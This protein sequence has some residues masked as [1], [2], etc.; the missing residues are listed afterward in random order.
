[1]NR[2]SEKVKDIVEVCPFTHLE[3]LSADAGLTLA[4]YHF[5]D[6]T[7]ELMAKW[8][9]RI[10]AVGPGRG[11]ALALAGFRGVGKSHFLAVL[12]G[13]MSAPELRSKI[14]DEHVAACAERLS[15]KHGV[16]ARV[17]RGSG[18]T[19]IE[20]L[21]RA[22][23]EALD[24]NPNTL[25]DSLNDLLLKGSEKANDLPLVVLIDTALGR[26][27]RVA[28][29]DGPF[30]SEIAEAAKTLG[31]F[32]GVALD[33][34]IAGADGA[35]SSI[36]AS[37]TIDY[38]D[39]EHLYKI[40]DTHIFAKQSQK[41][42]VLKQLYEDY[43]KQLPAFRWSEQR[44]TS[45]YPLHPAILEIAPLI[46]LYVQD[47]ALLGF[48]SEAGVKILG[49]PAN[50]LIGVDEVFDSVEHKLRSVGE[51]AD[52]FT[53]Y[54]KL[55][56]EVIAKAAVHSRLQAKLI[57][58]GL[59][60]LSLDSRGATADEIAAAM[61]LSS[62]D[63]AEPL[64]SSFHSAQP[65]AVQKQEGDGGKARYCF[66]LG[67]ADE[68]EAVLTAA[69]GTVTDEAVW[70][71][72]MR[73]TAEKFSEVADVGD[74][75][76]PFSIEW[77][78][79]IHRGS[80]DWHRS[81][82]E[83]S[84]EIRLVVEESIS[85]VG[86]KTVPERAL[87]W[88]LPG[89]TGEEANSLK[90]FHLLQYDAEVRAAY[91]DGIATATHI[92]SIAAEKIWQRV[93]L[94]DSVLVDGEA[95]YK[96]DE[97]NA[98]ASHSLAQLFS[99]SLSPVL[100]ARSPFHP[101][102]S[103]TLSAK[104][105]G[106][107]IA[108]FFGGADRD[109]TE[110]QKL[111]E[112]FALP[113]GLAVERDGG[114]VP[115][116]SDAMLHLGLSQLILADVDTDKVI[117]LA[118]IADRLLASP[119]GLTQEAQHL[120]LGALVGQKQFEFVTSSGNRIN[121]RSLDLQIIWD[122][123][124]GIAK[125]L[126]EE[127]SPARLVAWAKLITGNDSIT[128]MERSEDRLLIIDSLCTWLTGWRENFTL[129]KFDELSDANLNATIWKAAAGVRRS[130]EAMADAVEALVQNG[131]SLEECLHA[132]AELFTD[133]EED[134]ARKN[135]DLRAIRNWTAAAT[136]R[137]V[138]ANYLSHCA[139]TDNAEIERARQLVLEHLDS[140]DADFVKSWQAFKSLYAAFY[141]ERH[142]AASGVNAGFAEAL[143]SDSWIAFE[144]L[145][146]LPQ[147]DPSYM[148]QANELIRLARKP[149]CKGD[150]AAE[151][152]ERPYCSCGFDAKGGAIY[153]ADRLSRVTDKCLKEFAEKLTTDGQILSA[154]IDELAGDDDVELRSNVKQVLE[155]LAATGFVPFMSA[156]EIRLIKL[157]ATRLAQFRTADP[158]FSET[159]LDQPSD[160][161]APAL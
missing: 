156:A 158:S 18:S 124:V 40:V 1:M 126:H 15:R 93:F 37:Y 29:D 134:Y 73:Q 25:S 105:T 143:Q 67:A 89:L 122:D 12:A 133:S 119:F 36:S 42:S 155:D 38:L 19:L 27:T 11:A 132:I 13:V 138:I 147:I 152:V 151:L 57:L 21:R 55:E 9:D 142:D 14:Q 70:A 103:R 47:F 87:I 127:Y 56:A 99:S 34:D 90:R 45:L 48:A 141:V 153:F 10:A 79:A 22:I 75:A 161:L 69:L 76:T 50:S 135:S 62:G 3:D 28:R 77:R 98:R 30:L 78:G 137:N 130:F 81:V 101:E 60:I 6:I 96:F 33:D 157:A 58:K 88:R 149:A 59:F 116:A 86:A 5:T 65:D 104:Q 82:E 2:I 43:R 160:V 148:S 52:A 145:S 150:V 7:A 74:A 35:N 54:D 49:R 31:I 111:A 140:S 44:F 24:V 136:E 63:E 146:S 66:R 16:V 51:L 83:S 121:H 154:V 4:G 117:P 71:V 128:S 100:E 64:L 94:R 106:I 102:F 68:Y 110:V 80:V 39:Q 26:E 144:S 17:R 114:Y 115:E 107:L 92:H 112:A 95:E 8:I 118:H 120:V 72:L 131:A 85:G 61:A 84:F 23:A 123:I 41:L 91:G 159:V 108:E 125:P 139:V 53:V 109:N 20:E 32:V 97:E 129:S 113:L 46:R